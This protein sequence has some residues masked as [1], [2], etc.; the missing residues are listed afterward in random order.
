MFQIVTRNF[1]A[2]F[3]TFTVAFALFSST[4]FADSCDWY[5]RCSARAAGDWAPTSY[6]QWSNLIVFYID[7]S[8]HPRSRQLI[9]QA[10]E[11]WRPAMSSN[12]LGYVIKQTTTRTPHGIHELTIEGISGN[13]ILGV[14]SNHGVHHRDVIIDSEFWQSRRYTNQQRVAVVAHEIGHVIGLG[15]SSDHADLMYD[16]YNPTNLSPTRRDLTRASALLY[17]SVRRGYGYRY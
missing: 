1:T 15:H 17:E 12:R 7:K 2:A 6:D 8:L 10:I 3:L 5:G 4:T 11:L 16:H 14:T 9:E 13:D